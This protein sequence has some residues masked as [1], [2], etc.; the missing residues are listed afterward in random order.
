MTCDYIRECIGSPLEL[1]LGHYSSDCSRLIVGTLIPADATST[2][3]A[4]EL[5]L[6]YRQ[7]AA[8]MYN[9]ITQR[10]QKRQPRALL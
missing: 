4:S 1:P 5:E 10:V 3:L 6:S 8:G 9:I 2:A 7:L